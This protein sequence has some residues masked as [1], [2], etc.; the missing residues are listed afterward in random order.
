LSELFNELKRRNV[1]RVGIAYV[2]IA[3]VTAQVA[4]LALDSFEA[5]SWVIKAV[6]LLLALGLPVVLFFAWAFEMTP[7]GIKREKDV[8]RSQSIT[9]QT[10]RKLNRLIIGVLLIAVGVLL[11]DKFLLRTPDPAPAQASVVEVA[12]TNSVAVLPFVDMSPA[13]DQEYFTDGLTEN[14]LHAL[15]QIQ[16]LKVA[17]RTSSFAFKNKNT[18]LREIGEQLNVSNILEGSVQ[19]A[20][21]RVRIT[22]QLINAEDGYHLWSETFDRDLN[23]IF[24]VQDE[25]AAAVA[26]ALRKSL[27]GEA[28]HSTTTTN[29][30]EAYNAYLL[31]LSYYNKRTTADWDRAIEQFQL[32]TEKDPNMALAWAGLSRAHSVR[33]AFGSGF[34]EGFARARA[35]AQKALELDP[36]LADAH[37][38]LSE[39]QAT[40]D[41]D[42][43]GAAASLQRAA[44]LRPG[45]PDIIAKTSRLKRIRG[46]ELDAFE[47]IEEALSHDPLNFDL[48]RTRIGM[49]G[50][51]GRWDEALSE[52]QLLVRTS[53]ESG[54]VNYSL[55]R[56]YY[57]RGELQLSLAA[58]K[59]EVF[60][61]LRLEH[62]AILH[63]MLGDQEMAQQKLDEL[64]G[65]YGDDVS[66]Q[67]ARVYAAWGDKDQTIAALERGFAIRDPGLVFVKTAREI[68]GL[69]GDD[70]RLADLL[71]RMNLL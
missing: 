59:N 52:A 40:F 63:N 22:T 9:P 60:N 67:V 57:R 53:P 44:E 62:E 54:G 66:W 24:V 2:L 28:S 51:L 34:A 33:T 35:A 8:D 5:P 17:G 29:D 42:W 38:A 36:N 21:N 58:V 27:L 10:G 47:D 23:D 1:V 69:L 49:L 50:Q 16:E 15:A 25:I 65:L 19:K 7:E 31:G 68:N 4:E 48:K 14:L 71:E 39:V 6:L 18:D 11:A 30:F 56:I 32:A 70:P 43:D 64:I 61:F 45:D 12:D 26:R 37:L 20:G 46:E 55:A 13:K 41:W 3:W